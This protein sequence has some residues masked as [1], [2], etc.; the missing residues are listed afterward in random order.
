MI[1]FENYIWRHAR[2][3]S[4]ESRVNAAHNLMDQF[5]PD[6]PLARNSNPTPPNLP[7]SGEEQTEHSPWQ[8]GAG[9]G[10]E[11]NGQSGFNCKQRGDL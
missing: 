2:R 9:G 11:A 8:G 7:L 1:D 6:C 3:P 10:F 5:N 4:K